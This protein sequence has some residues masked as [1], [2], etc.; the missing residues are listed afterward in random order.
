MVSLFISHVAKYVL[1]RKI[2]QGPLECYFG[3]QRQKAVG[4]NHHTSVYL[5]KILKPRYCKMFISFWCHYECEYW[6]EATGYPQQTQL[7]LCFSNF[8]S[9]FAY[10]MAIFHYKMQLYIKKNLQ[11]LFQKSLYQKVLGQYFQRQYWQPRVSSF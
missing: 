11:W 10:L 6:S 9:C 8:F 4:M 5:L 7:N 1:A 3:H 2:N